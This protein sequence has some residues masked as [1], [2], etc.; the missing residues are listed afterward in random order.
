[1]ELRSVTNIL[2]M[3]GSRNGY[4]SIND[5]STKVTVQNNDEYVALSQRNKT[6]RQFSIIGI[7][8]SSIVFVLA[9]TG[10]NNDSNSPN[11]GFVLERST[12]Y[13]QVVHP[14]TPSS[15]W[16][17][18]QKPFPT[19]AFWTNLVVKNGDGPIGVLPYGI[20]TIETG[21]QVSYGPSRR[22]VTQYFISDPFN[23]DLQISAVQ[24]YVSRSVESYDNSSVTMAYKTNNGGKY[25]TH[26][27]KGSPFITVVY[28]NTTPVI[29]SD[30]MKI[31]DVEAKILK[32][33]DGVQYII[34]LGNYQKWLLYCS[35]PIGFSWKE[36]SLIGGL[37]IHG[38]IRVSVLPMQNSLESFNALIPY[39]KK[40]PTSAIWSFNFVSSSVAEA[41]IQYNTVGTGPLLMLALP[42][43]TTI[44]QTPNLKSDDIANLQKILNPIYSIKG[45]M[46]VVIGEQWKL[47]FNLVQVGWNYVPSDK[48]SN[49]QMDEIARNLIIDVTE[50]LTPAT[51][52]YAF[53][54]QMGRMARLALIADEFGIP[55]VRQQA[56]LN[57]ESNLLPWLTGSNANALLYDKT[58]GGLVPTHGLE[59]SVNEF[60][61]G[62]YSDHHFHYGYFIYALG[63]TQYYLFI[64]LF[65]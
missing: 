22:V 8:F 30:I 61:S 14:E 33:N 65:C 59:A 19:G 10:N 64:H 48:L 43:Q 18:V 16:G 32:G 41:N 46:K 31:L 50:V 52:P 56:I 35:E 29:T 51:D 9:F 7:I 44:M 21:I 15:Y 3:N 39:V 63:E 38:F 17:V 62:W 4:S 60:G 47:L 11:L 53:G 45:K 5:E 34:T 27:V 36:N 1:M 24:G 23:I 54:K 26:L 28:D 2:P 58:W 55:N 40:Y 42:H 20:K 49:S 6:I 37:P 57:L 12:T 25:K 13:K